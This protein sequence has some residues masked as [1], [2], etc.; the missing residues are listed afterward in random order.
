ML[1]KGR[2]GGEHTR[3][4]GAEGFAP[5]GVNATRRRPSAA[6]LALEPPMETRVSPRAGD[7]HRINGGVL[8]AL[9][10]RALVALAHRLPA[11]VT[12]DQLTA[13]G[14][15]AMAATGAAFAAAGL[16]R[17]WLLAVPVTL[18][19]NW[20]GDSLDGTLARVRRT[21][22]PR[23]GYYVDHVLDVFGTTLLLAGMGASGFM[24]PVVAAATLAAYL[25]VSAEV[26]LATAVRG[27]FRMSFLAMGPTELRILI[28]AGAV[29]LAWK[30]V[31]HPFGLGPVLLLD[32]GGLG[33][34]A[35]LLVAFAT[36]AVRT[37]AAL[38]R[39]EPLPAREPGVPARADGSRLAARLP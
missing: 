24:T 12:S 5:S 38:Y 25:L 37:T 17:R 20:F 19:L 35:G 1:A 15:L 9:E 21:P 29:V 22:R 11:R 16:D 36:A 2:A 13:L 6:A 10:R 31:V 39:E 30:P 32:V 26:F 33:A 23:F 28:A 8:A 14:L 4:P 7:H 18:A 27:E 3:E 34:I